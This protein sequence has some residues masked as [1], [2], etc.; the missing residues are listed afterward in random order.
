MINHRY[1]F[2]NLI[3]KE[4]WFEGVRTRHIS[5]GRDQHISINFRRISATLNLFFN[6]I[7]LEKTNSA[8]KYLIHVKTIKSSGHSKILKIRVNFP[9]FL[10]LRVIF[11]KGS[12]CIDFFVV[13]QERIHHTESNETKITKIGQLRIKLCKF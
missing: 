13:L 12:N 5:G 2:N 6:Y 9:I 7:K 3:N 4:L 8:L 11:W 10:L 1:S